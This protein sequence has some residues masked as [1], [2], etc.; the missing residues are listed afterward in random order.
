MNPLGDIR[1]LPSDPLRSR[2]VN[3]AQRP[4]ASV[5]ERSRSGSDVA[6][7]QSQASRASAF[8]LCRCALP[9][10]HLNPMARASHHD[11]RVS[12]VSR[13]PIAF[14]TSGRSRPRT[15]L[16]RTQRRG[17]TQGGFD[18]KWFLQTKSG[19]HRPP[20]GDHKANGV[21]T[22]EVPAAEAAH[23][24]AAKAAA[25]AGEM[26]ATE[27]AHVAEV[28]AGEMTATELAAGEAAHVAEVSAGEM[29]ATEL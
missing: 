9:A 8:D 24:P 12:R 26:T 28:C 29:T 25:E 23:V 16:E 4:A 15:R 22:V 7:A 17:P 1:W 21:L 19:G 18:L 2:F 10:P 3:E 5:S 11:V 27:A 6:V 20:E 13:W 14:R